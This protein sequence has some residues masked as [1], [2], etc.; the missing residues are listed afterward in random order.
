MVVVRVVVLDGAILLFSLVVLVSYP[1][2]VRAVHVVVRD[3]GAMK[4]EEFA[5]L[6]V[7]DRCLVDA[8]GVMNHGYRVL[9]P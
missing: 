1:D 6:Q 7:R 5:L 8:V 3:G 9:Y 4:H 2:G